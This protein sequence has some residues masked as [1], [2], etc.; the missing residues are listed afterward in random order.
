MYVFH[1]TEFID[2]IMPVLNVVH[3]QSY[4]MKAFLILMMKL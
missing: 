4:L 1:T 2:G 3:L